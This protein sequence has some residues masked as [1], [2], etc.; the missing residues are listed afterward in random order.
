MEPPVRQRQRKARLL[1]WEEGLAGCDEA[2]RGPL[3]GPVVCAAVLIPEGF[4]LDGVDDSKRLSPGQRE[5]QAAR[6]KAGTNWAIVCVPPE[7]I[8]RVN[9]LRAS[10]E[11]MAE[12]LR[13]LRPSPSRV[14]VDGT[15]PV[16]YS[17]CDVFAEPK[18]DGT[19]ASVAAAGIL[20]KVAR[21]EMM[22]TAAL[23]YPE[24]GFDLHFGY[25]TPEHLAAL[26]EFG[27]CPIHRRTF[28]PVSDMV[29]QPCLTFD[30]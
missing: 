12:A 29:N 10:L 21:D 5:A 20:A 18:A 28:S 8:D 3:A 6:I 23:T 27:P 14:V 13:S 9:I 4:E 2:G 17:G 16:P 30:A 26:R 7:E 1:R 15:W 19:Y 24:Y 22:R 11:G 25:P